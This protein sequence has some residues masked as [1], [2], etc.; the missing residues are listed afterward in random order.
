MDIDTRARLEARL[1]DLTAK[2]AKLSASLD[3]A[4]DSADVQTYSLTD[5]EGGQS[6]TRRDP[7]KLMALISSLDI[8]I[9]SLSAQLAGGGLH[10]ANLR[11]TR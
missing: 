4:L 2:R 7:E 3:A 10:I 6:V 1:A 5:P 8:Q 9:D 11:R